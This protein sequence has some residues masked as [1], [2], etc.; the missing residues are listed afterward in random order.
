MQA[1]SEQAVEPSV[2]T[3]PA[4]QQEQAGMPQQARTL[5]AKRDPEDDT[6]EKS[7]AETSKKPKHD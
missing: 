4:P 7:V 3:P 2:E 6:K 5:P 1:T